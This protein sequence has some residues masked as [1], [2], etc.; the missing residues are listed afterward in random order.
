MQ[1]CTNVVYAFTKKN[2][3]YVGYDTYFANVFHQSALAHSKVDWL[4]SID[5]GPHTA[6]SRFKRLSPSLLLKPA[7]NV[8]PVQRCS[9]A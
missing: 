4:Y 9:P 1:R 5:S 8:L 6:S 7:M 3:F 2:K